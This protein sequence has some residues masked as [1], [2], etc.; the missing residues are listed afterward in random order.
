M[1]KQNV[2]VSAC[3]LGIPCRYDGRS[4]SFDKMEALISRANVVPFCAEVYGGL[5]TPRPS[6]EIQPN[7]GRVTTEDQTDVT[8]SYERGAREAVRIAKTLNCRYALL[9]DKSPSCGVGTV[10]NGSFTRTLAPGYGIT[11][12]ALIDAGVRVFSSA[13]PDALLNALDSD[14]L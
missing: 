14:V 7:T 11:A 9:K 4:V 3:L 1:R 2:L 12:R 6:A 13:E 10:Y 5:P 8:D